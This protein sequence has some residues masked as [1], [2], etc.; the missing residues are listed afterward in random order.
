MG[1]RARL[2]ALTAA[3]K[4]PNPDEDIGKDNGLLEGEEDDENDLPGT[5]EERDMDDES[6]EKLA[7]MLEKFIESQD[8]EDAEGDGAQC[9][10][11]EQNSDLKDVDLGGG[12]AM[13]ICPS[14]E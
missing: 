7:E 6:E 14:W 9:R 12:D 8:E 11:R 1:I 10:H 5:P 4:T 3:A 13:D 2:S